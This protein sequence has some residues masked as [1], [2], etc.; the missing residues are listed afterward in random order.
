MISELS[1][2]QLSSMP[3]SV[4]APQLMGAEGDEGAPGLNR[5][6]LQS[7]SRDSFTL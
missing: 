3:P 6:H 5:A 1:S 2:L 4:C 7:H